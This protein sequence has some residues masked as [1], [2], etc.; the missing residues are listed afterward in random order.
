MERHRVFFFEKK[1]QKT[2]TRLFLVW[3]AALLLASPSFAQTPTYQALTVIG[4][5]SVGGILTI[6]TPTGGD[7]STK[8]A[9]TAFVA[10]AIAPL[11]P[12]AS[13]ALTGTPTAPTATG[14]DSSTRIATT[15]FVAA[16]I[17][18]LAPKASP[19]FTG[20][21]T[22]PQFA[23]TNGTNIVNSGTSDSSANDF[24]YA[25]YQISGSNGA[26]EGNS[27][28]LAITDS[29][30]YF[31]P[32]AYSGL[33]VVVTPQASA[34][35]GR[36]ALYGEI[37]LGI[38]RSPGD[39]SGM[40]HVGVLGYVYSNQQQGGAIGQRVVTTPSGTNPQG[41]IWAGIDHA[42]LK[43]GA[44]GFI[45][46][47]ARETENEN[48]AGS[49]V[50]LNMG[51]HISLAATHAQRGLY[52][53][54]GIC[55]GE[56]VAGRG[57]DPGWLNV[58]SVGEPNSD[59]PTGPDS[60]ILCTFGRIYAQNPG[61]YPLK[62]ATGIDLRDSQQTS[63][64]WAWA[65]KGAGI[66]DVGALSANGVTTTG[67]IQALSATVSGAT[68]AKGGAFTSFPSILI[69][70]PPSGGTT[71]TGTVTGMA[72]A[73]IEAFYSTG[74]NY[75]VGDTGTAC[76]G[77]GVTVAYVDSN[78]GIV[79]PTLT[80]GAGSASQPPLT[81]V[82]TPVSVHGTGATFRCSYTQST[83]SPNFVL[84]SVSPGTSGS[85]LT[86]G[87]TIAIAA[88]SGD[89]GTAPTFTANSV[90]SF[91]ALQ[92]SSATNAPDLTLAT[93]GAMTAINPTPAGE[94]TT[95]GTPAHYATGGSN[96]VVGYAITSVSTTPGAGYPAAPP[97]LAWTYPN[98]YQAGNVLLTMATTAAPLNL[99]AAGGAVNVTPTGLSAF[100]LPTFL[101]DRKDAKMLGAAGDGVTNDYTVLTS[102]GAPL[103]LTSGQFFT[104]ASVWGMPDGHW[105]SGPGGTGRLLM[106]ESSVN[107]LQA[108]NL[109][110]ITSAPTS[111]SNY[112]TSGLNTAF[113]APFDHV[114]YAAGTR[115]SGTATLG[116]PTSGYQI[117][118]LASMA[119]WNMYNGSGWNNST[120][121]NGGRTGV[122]QHFLQFTQ[123]GQGDLTAV[124]VNGYVSGTKAGATSFLANG[125]G[126]LIGGQVFGG[127][128]GVYLQIIGDGN[129]SDNGYD[130]SC[131]GLVFNLNRTNVT[132]NFG[133]TWMAIRP[134][135]PNTG[136]NKSIDAFYSMGGIAVIGMDFTGA[137]LK[138]LAGTSVKSA[139]TLGAGQA[140]YGNATNTDPTTYAR[141]TNAGTEYFD[142]E[143]TPGWQMV[144]GGTTVFNVNASSAFISPQL[145]LGASNQI[146]NGSVATVLG[147]LGPT[148]S[149]TTVQEW[150]QVKDAAGTVRFIPMF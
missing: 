110:I 34:S 99:N 137:V 13:P 30:N 144:V 71:A 84:N 37:N 9:T 90:D 1:N 68:V 7:S 136:S 75:Q 138:S 3:L 57:T 120:S 93:A 114:H 26:G 133:N 77:A 147:S 27:A 131:I 98:V 54:C 80:P 109:A 73:A 48:A 31:G 87:A 40:P 117:N 63:G 128:N 79:N 94:Y 17:S 145:Q 102:N 70:S 143:A 51:L 22:L 134:Q 61:A 113:A 11:A 83:S 36:N 58:M 149:H 4:N 44:T 82:M 130:V 103:V 141:Y 50:Q 89:T 146:A 121:G 46:T 104:N 21:V 55:W 59:G 124:F 43:S 29:V 33:R 49:S 45:Q 140:I 41:M 14:G 116:Q 56:N 112:S 95:A 135:S 47:I 86:Q 148:G 108:P 88:N 28:R 76:G 127:A 132:G 64:G 105:V 39:S 16:A 6:P 60:C 111:A 10:G 2:F 62:F 18:P 32:N 15:A 53:D 122:A 38:Q 107:T 8:A 150:M 139:I 35:G 92:F 25:N 106:V 5:A 115:I 91:G 42:Q 24:L 101:A 81:S 23:A 69:Q 125:A 72:G 126:S 12:L 74:K 67:G 97:P 78:G 142:Y 119:Y 85:G 52:E 20:I 65:S 100:S 96:L 123:G 129:C 66:S 118:P 19:T